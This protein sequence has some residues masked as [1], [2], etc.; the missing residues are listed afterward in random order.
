VEYSSKVLPIR[1]NRKSPCHF[2]LKTYLK[3]YNNS[4][5][6]RCFPPSVTNHEENQDLLSHF[7][8]IRVVIFQPYITS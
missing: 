2:S 5:Y 8:G 6:S 4:E 1:P 3:T 7:Y